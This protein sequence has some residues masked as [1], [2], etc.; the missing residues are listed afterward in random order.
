MAGEYREERFVELLNT[1]KKM[2]R[3]TPEEKKRRLGYFR[4]H[5]LHD[6]M[7]MDLLQTLKPEAYK[8]LLNPQ[9]DKSNASSAIV[10][11]ASG[12]KEVDTEVFMEAINEAI[13][14]YTGTKKDG[15]EYTFISSVKL[16]YQQ[17]AGRAAAV[18][19]YQNAQVMLPKIPERNMSEV[20]KL[21][22]DVRRLK[23]GLGNQISAEV[24]LDKILKDTDNSRFCTSQMR[25]AVINIVDN[26]YAKISMNIT[27]NE[28]DEHDLSEIL[29]KED[30][31][32]QRVEDE[33]AFRQLLEKILKYLEA[34]WS[35]VEAGTDK[36]TRDLFRAFFTKE[37]L[38]LLKLR[39]VGEKVG[40]Q[41][42]ANCR[43]WCPRRSR[44]KIKRD[45]C[46]V[47]YEMEPAGNEEIYELL[48]PSGEKLCQK[49]F[50]KK[51]LERAVGKKNEQLIQIYQKVLKD[52]FR[53]TDAILG[54]ALNR[55]KTQ[56]SKGRKKYNIYME[57]LYR[58]LINQ[59]R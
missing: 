58:F 52:D 53:F 4:K 33:H 16:N 37:I 47:R 50:Q 51:Y 48:Q 10:S 42:E 30:P 27:V 20:L 59:D 35:L 39:Y 9:F 24:L 28:E 17:C 21:V 49:I 1:L 3:S 11:A 31:G 54:E 43:Q 23:E 45:G 25:E 32:F 57:E 6:K 29:G 40:S 7:I 8:S 38:I 55:E 56:I 18:H 5:P 36:Q 13:Q 44:C 26:L 19:D 14:K 12:R 46:Y 2:P 22:K 41:A 15:T 34:S